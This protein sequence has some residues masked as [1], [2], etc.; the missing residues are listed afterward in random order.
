[1]APR[2][3]AVALLV[4][5]WATAAVAEGRNATFGV[6]VRVVAR[7]RARPVVAPV[8]SSFVVAPGRVS[9]PCGAEVSPGCREAV[10]AAALVSGAPVVVTAFTDGTPSAVLER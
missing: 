7:L 8:P 9:L 1:M 10:T 3:I 5:L 6:S 2:R 4:A